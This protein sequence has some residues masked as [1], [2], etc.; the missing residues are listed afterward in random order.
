M[1]VAGFDKVCDEAREKE[2]EGRSPCRHEKQVK[3]LREFASWGLTDHRRVGH[4]Y[5]YVKPVGVVDGGSRLRVWSVRGGRP[6]MGCKRIKWLAAALALA[7]LA[8]GPAA[9]A[10]WN[11]TGA[12]PYT[13]SDTANWDGGAIDHRFT[14]NLD[15]SQT[16]QFNANT[17]RARGGGSSGH[18]GPAG[19]RR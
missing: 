11:Q 4:S 14:N 9:R 3:N 18:E 1:V 17:Q 16:V 8:P 2:G 5:W 10:G 7:C 15:A 6:M 19:S 12:G 13:Y